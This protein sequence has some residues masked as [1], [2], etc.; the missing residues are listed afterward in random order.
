MVLILVLMVF[1][2]AAVIA[3]QLSYDSHRELRRTANILHNNESYL[4]ARAG[5][6]FAIQ[7]L[8]DDYNYDQQSGLK[9]DYLTES[10]AVESQPYTV[11]S[12]AKNDTSLESGQL[13]K[14]DFLKQEN[15][16]AALKDIGELVIIIEDLQARFNLNNVQYKNPGH[17]SGVAQ[18]NNVINAV[19]AA[20]VQT[21]QFSQQENAE[22]VTEIANNEW[23]VPVT[24]IVFALQ[25]WID[26]D[27][28]SVTSGSGEDDFYNQKTPAYQAANQEIVDV[29]EVMAI[30]GF[31]QDEYTFYD[32]LFPKR[33]E[34]VQSEN[35][36]D[37]EGELGA[38]QDFADIDA[39]LQESEKYDTEGNLIPELPSS[40][41]RWGG[42]QNYF[43]ALPFRSKI[44]VNTAP[45]VVLQALFTSEQATKIITGREGSPYQTVDDIFLNLTEI[46]SDDKE[47]YT[48]Y[49]SVNSQYFLATSIA[50]IGETKFTLRS[51]LY[52]NEKG[53][54][55]VLSRDFSF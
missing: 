28:D 18:T 34:L 6:V 44:N 55:K 7:K 43:S 13:V 48:P 29:S 33:F 5:E 46:K 17:V 47:K 26:K 42:V 1:A 9:A 10:W 30:K 52:R 27:D 54:V 31:D 50:T 23:T 15:P 40:V 25:D 21:P 14:N 49:L 20:G 37:E 22:V 45:A 2:L 32:L 38:E 12:A 36:S 3:G 39:S 51:K 53:E 16:S 11:D 4:F 41:E 24:E 19:L 35:V 8:L